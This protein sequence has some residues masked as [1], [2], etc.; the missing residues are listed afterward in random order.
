VNLF[1][2]TLALLDRARHLRT[3]FLLR[4]AAEVGHDV[5]V[6]GLVWIHGGGS[7]FLGDRVMFDGRG[8][9]IELHALPGGEIHIG[10][11]VT[12]EGGTSIEA[13][14]SVTVGERCRVGGFCKIIDNH[15]HPLR[16]ERHRLPGS[17]PIVIYPEVELGRHVLVLPGA[18]VRRGSVVR[19]STVL[20]GPPLSVVRPRE[21]S[22]KAME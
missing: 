10:D 12:I 1:F 15:F 20:R 2:E 6:G 11:D 7:V 14:H 9:P 16:G 17:V 4:R 3:R 13:R 18:H 5:W 19:P 21:S 22:A 8:A